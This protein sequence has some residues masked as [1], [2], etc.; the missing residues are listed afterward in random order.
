MTGE[1]DPS[2]FQ[3]AVEQR[4]VLLTRNHDDFQEL[5]DLVLA[6]RGHHPGILVVR[7]DNDRAKDMTVR[8]AAVAVRNVDK[9]YTSLV[10]TFLILNHWR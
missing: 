2:Q 6:A 8:G 9:A 7:R 10:D 4:R 1:T 5:H 3:Y